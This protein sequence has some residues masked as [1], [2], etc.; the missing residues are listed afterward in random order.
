MSNIVLKT[1]EARHSKRSF[2]KKDVPNSIL[3]EVLVF[4]GNAPSSKNTQ[5]W[6]VSVLK[7]K[8]RDELSKAMLEKFD[9]NIYEKDDFVYSVE[10]TPEVYRERARQ[11]GYSLFE[12]K[13]I[14]RYDKPQR[15]EHDRQNFLFFGAPVEMIFY[16]PKKAERGNFLD[17]GFF[18][19][20]VMLGL[21]SHGV[22]S[23][24][25]VSVAG[26]PDT[27]RKVLELPDDTCIVSG[28]SCGYANDDKVNTFIP[29][30]LKLEEYT[31]FYE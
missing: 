31:T 2:L 27:I 3:E 13:G 9:Q 23:C 17:L 6:Q 10:P 24:P 21:L 25:Q 18:M 8:K 19:Q 14:D 28:L 20:N 5:P 1:I 16:L 4:A 30:R 12:L 29:P 7:G 22:S 15:K 26:Y 11:C